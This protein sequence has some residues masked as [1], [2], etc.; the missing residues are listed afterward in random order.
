MWL[1]AV[2]MTPT[3]LKFTFPHE[4]LNILSHVHGWRSTVKALTALDVH[5]R[6]IPIP[7]RGTMLSSYSR[8][9][10][11]FCRGPKGKTS[12]FSPKLKFSPSNSNSS[13]CGNVT[14]GKLWVRHGGS[15]L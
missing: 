15:Y 11:A 14:N 10:M 7:G 3:A 8:D 5:G 4:L 6:S 13:I 12:K 9:Y 1:E 2:S